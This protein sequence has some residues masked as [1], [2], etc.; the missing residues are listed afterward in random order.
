MT[1]DE[2]EFAQASIE[3]MTTAIV[4]ISRALML[5]E[6]EHSNAIYNYLFKAKISLE[7]AQKWLGR[8]KQ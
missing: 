7:N 1:K 8:I 6:H 4:G 2:R 3:S 5:N